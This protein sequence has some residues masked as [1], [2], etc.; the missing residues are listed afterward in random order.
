MSAGR[1]PLPF[2]ALLLVAT[3]APATDWVHWRGPEQDGHVNGVNL[4]DSFSLD[5]VGKNGLIWKKPVGGRSAPIKVGNRLFF[6]NAFDIGLLTEGERVSCL[7]ATTGEA[8]WHHNMN[9]YHADVVTGRLGWTTMT[10]DPENKRVY[11]HTTSGEVLCLD[12]DGKVVW[13]RQLSEEFG[14]FTGYG[15]RISSPIFDSGLVIVGCVVSSW[16]DL[17]KGAGRYLAFDGATGEVVWITEPEPK[18]RVLSTY[19]SNPVIAVI[20]GQRLFIQGGADGAMHALKVRTGERVW[21]YHFGSG[22]INPSPVVDGNLVYCA[23]GEENPEGGPIGRVV[24]VD[25]SQID[26]KTLK[27]KLVWEYRRSNRFGLSSPA[28]ADGKLYI[29]DDGAELFCFDGKTGKKLWTYKYGTVARGAPLIADNKVYI[30]DVTA[31]LAVIKLNGNK[32][33]DEA[34]TQEFTFRVP[35]G[36]PGFCETHGTPIAVDGRL[37]FSTQFDTYCVGDPNAKP[38]NWKPISL[39]PETPFKKDAAPTSIRIYPFETTT[40]PGATVAVKLHYLDANGREVDPPAG[41]MPVWSLPAPPV[42]PAPA[43]TPMAPMPMTPPATAAGTPPPAA[44]PAGPPP[45][46]ATI[47][48]KGNDI[49]LK[50][51][52]MPPGQSG[53]VAVKDG[54]MTARARVRVVPQIPYKQDFDKVP[55]GA[56]PGGWVNTQGKFLVKKLPTG[57][58]VLSKVNTNGAPP[59]A[60]A[61]GY[62]TPTNSS[63]YLIEGDLMGTEVRGKCPDMGLVAS[64]YT[65][66]LDGKNDPSHNGQHT[67]RLTTWEARPRISEVIAF[68]WK[69]DT[70]YHM[71]LTVAV[72]GKNA[73]IK[74]KVWEKGQ[75]EPEKWTVTFSDP[76]PNLEGAAGVYGYVSNVAA[77]DA[78]SDIYYD[79]IAVTPNK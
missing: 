5:A 58:T 21:T 76:S 34:D 64:R 30:F 57:E 22:A 45:M 7:D 36:Q 29:P 65:L 9:V 20:G 69:K 47:T 63:G 38:G 67:I 52:A 33:P 66:I 3:S 12:T 4:P 59:V 43:P 19:Q 54:A 10:A 50:I 44:A 48:P 17:A 77:P 75:P 14:R 31:K 39:Q 8:V 70:W 16:G 78:G 1:F 73:E 42:P 13:R 25:G 55:V 46:K 71:K 35:T 41:A 27:P 26:P 23:H 15:G 53:Y 18:L 60:K 40:K 79:N 68:P 6:L 24:C 61:N 62:C 56:V 28:F 32:Q 11:A 2:L 37:Y 51:D 49:E 74:G 72:V